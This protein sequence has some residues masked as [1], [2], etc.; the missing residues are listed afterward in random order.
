MAEQQRSFTVWNSRNDRRRGNALAPRPFYCG[1]PGTPDTSAGWARFLSMN[2]PAGKTRL[3]ASASSP[4]SSPS[5]QSEEC[6]LKRVHFT[7][8]SQI[9]LYSTL[10]HHNQCWSKCF[11]GKHQTT[12]KFTSIKL[13]YINSFHRCISSA[14]IEGQQEDMSPEHRLECCKRF[15]SSY[16]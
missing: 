11:T 9:Y 2:H 15:S 5:A 13:K 14:Q 4:S 7:E 3:S 12:W 6:H 10:Q 8:W 16:L 1:P